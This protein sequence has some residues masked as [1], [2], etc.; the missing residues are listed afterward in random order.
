MAS[1][2]KRTPDGELR[3]SQLLNTFGP[4][5]LVDLPTRSVVI[6]GLSYWKGEPHLVFSS[7]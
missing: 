4:G 3:Q 2:E 1:K 5:A 6:A 7:N